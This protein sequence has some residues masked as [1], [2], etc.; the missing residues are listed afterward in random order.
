MGTVSAMV[1]IDTLHHV[2]AAE[3]FAQHAEGSGV[4]CAAGAAAAQLGDVPSKRAS[5]V[6]L[7][8][9]CAAAAAAAALVAAAAAAAIRD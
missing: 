7:S 5:M 9:C 4:L 3:G 2:P 1:G 6:L 8:C